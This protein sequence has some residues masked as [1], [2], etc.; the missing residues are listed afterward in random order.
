M[1]G[2]L[3]M[4]DP[5]KSEDFGSTKSIDLEA[6][7]TYS[8]DE[9]LRFGV[10]DITPT[11]LDE[12]R[13]RAQLEVER[14]QDEVYLLKDRLATIRARAKSVIDT[15]RMSIDASAR[16]QL[17]DYPWTK[18]AGAFIATYGAGKVLRYMPMGLIA[19][20]ALRRMISGSGR[21]RR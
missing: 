17:G 10:D 15:Q 3:S 12:A 11:P 20:L 18:L 6:E 5:F 4:S 2:D 19:T 16:A 8:L 7:P 14:L 13:A 21:S 1:Q 9:D